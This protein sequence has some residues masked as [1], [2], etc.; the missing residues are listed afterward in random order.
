MKC[1]C[2]HILRLILFTILMLSL[3]SIFLLTIIADYPI[4][5]YNIKSVISS[6]F[7]LKYLFG[8]FHYIAIALLVMYFL[9]KYLFIVLSIIYFLFL[10]GVTILIRV[11]IVCET[12]GNF[13]LIPD[14]SLTQQI[15]TFGFLSLF[16]IV[17]FFI[18]K[19]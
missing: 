18:Y 14:L 13:G 2:I 11:S 17:L 6:E 9:H 19:K 5:N 1:N 3:V 16:S 10:L 8:Y 15:F 7:I 4:I 12:C